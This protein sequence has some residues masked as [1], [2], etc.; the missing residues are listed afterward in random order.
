MPPWV[1]W[2]GAAGAVW[3]GVVGVIHRCQQYRYTRMIIVGAQ[4]RDV[5]VVTE[6]RRLGR[7][8]AHIV[9]VTDPLEAGSGE[10][11][12]ASSCCSEHF[13]R[14]TASG[15]CCGADRNTDG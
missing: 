10:V 2:L 1:V 12:D 15:D 7:G 5:R 6:F 4:G 8:Y 11:D 9:E 3:L 13:E 14:G